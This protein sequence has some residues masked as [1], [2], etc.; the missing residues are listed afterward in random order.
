[1]AVDFP[2]SQSSDDCGGERRVCEQARLQERNRPYR[3]LGRLCCHREVKDALTL[4]KALGV[5]LSRGGTPF[6]ALLKGLAMCFN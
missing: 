2:R 1:M 6:L 4:P 3:I 5:P